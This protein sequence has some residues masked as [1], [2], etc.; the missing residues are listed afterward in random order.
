MQIYKALRKQTITR[1]RCPQQN[2][3]VFSNRRNS[4]GEYVQSHVDGEG[5]CSTDA[6]QQQ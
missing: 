3:C 6:V 5:G 2:M 4:T 1:R